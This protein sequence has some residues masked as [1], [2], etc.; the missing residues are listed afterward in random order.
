MDLDAKKFKYGLVLVI[1]VLLVSMVLL[2]L[3]H[4]G[5]RYSKSIDVLEAKLLPAMQ[6]ILNADR[7]LYQARTAELEA[8]SLASTQQ[9]HYVDIHH[10][11]AQQAK[12]GMLNFLILLR[13]FPEVLQGLEVFETYFARWQ[14][15]SSEVFYLLDS[16][17]STKAEQLSLNR[18]Y[19]NFIE[20]RELYNLAG[21]SAEQLNADLTL[22]D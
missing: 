5:V 9:Q 21:E 19:Q 22:K 6:E 4:V 7:H 14:Q 12:Q 1:N 16:G 3:S 17:Q 18:G 2:I 15:S 20:L 10:Q 11:H 8:I 13:D